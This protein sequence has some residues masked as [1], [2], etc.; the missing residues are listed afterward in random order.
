LEKI[1]RAV[2]ARVFPLSCRDAA[3]HTTA[4][5]LRVDPLAEAGER[6]AHHAAELAAME[7]RHRAEL[8]QLES[9]TRRRLAERARQRLL[10]IAASRRRREAS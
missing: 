2:E 9:E 3:A 5:A 6:E 10:E 1:R 4:A 7:E 8:E